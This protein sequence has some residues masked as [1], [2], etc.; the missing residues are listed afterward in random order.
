L[1]NKKKNAAAAQAEQA[2]HEQLAALQAEL[3]EV[4]GERTALEAR[5]ADLGETNQ[6]LDQRLAALD[7]GVQSMGEQLVTL[8]SSTTETS[9]RVEAIDGR[10]EVVEGL[11]AD[12]SAIN[13][14]LRSFEPAQPSPQPPPPPGPAPAPT[15]QP[16]SLS[17]P[18]WIDPPPPPLVEFDAPDSVDERIAELRDQ[19]DELV[20]QT[21]S[22]DARVSSVSMELAN[23]LTELS[24][25]IDELN[26]RS[27]QTGDS[28][29]SDVDT[30]QL[31][32]RIAERLDAAMDDVLDSTERL[33]AEQARYEIAFRA[34]L[35]ELAE[36]IRRPGAT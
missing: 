9:R 19:L 26:R 36:R 30:A 13:E 21:S 14:R 6:Q 31:E 32:A 3:D 20:R 4:R 15:D 25:D 7:Q 1:F 12:L 2:R 16:P 17:E 11:G 18:S 22:I 33:A 23:Q 24:S 29:G 10:V 35:A 5:I 34:D 28:S 8:S 27:S